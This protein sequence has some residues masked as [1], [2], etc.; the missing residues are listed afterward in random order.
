MNTPKLPLWKL[1]FLLFLIGSTVWII[2]EKSA[3]VPF[4]KSSGKVFGTVYHITYQYPIDL[5]DS[6]YAV[7]MSV[8]NSLSP[9]NPRSTITAI[10]ENRSMN[11]D[12]LFREVFR[13]AQSISEKTGGN[14]DITVAPLVNAWGF[15]FRN[16]QNINRSYIDSLRQFI[17]Y[18]KISLCGD[19]VLKQ[20]ERIL[21]DCS[22]IA[23]GYGCD[24]VADFLSR[25]GITNYMIEIGGEI[26]VKGINPDKQKW[27]IGVNKP[28][29]D[30]LDNHELQTILHISETALAT[31]GNYR[32][33]YYKNGR[34][35][36]HTINPH[37]GY[38]TEHALLSATV[39]APTCA[40]ADAYA[41]A[42]MVAGLEQAK[43]ILRTEQQ[44]KAYLIYT[45]NNGLLRT[46]FSPA[47]RKD[48]QNLSASD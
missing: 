44:L 9:F 24:R 11:T 39:F 7:L 3:T 22:A 6:I 27:K 2:R 26:V 1:F 13:M 16:K 21:L 46:W 30:S 40:M 18:E 12:T 34:K 8:D 20:D 45:D 42:F 38:P 10:N 37:T 36:A 5:T 19:K 33:F 28:T 25:K 23:K 47:L 17:G 48:I 35:Y 14:F 41:T 32:N 29:E 4:Q 43:K 31:S 15:G